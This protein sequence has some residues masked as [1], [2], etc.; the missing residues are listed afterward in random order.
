MGSLVGD[1][2]VSLQTD[3]SCAEGKYWIITEII[4]ETKKKEV[5]RR[6]VSVFGDSGARETQYMKRRRSDVRPA[7]LST[8]NK[9]ARLVEFDSSEEDPNACLG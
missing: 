8:L 6:R 3:Q 4:L 9:N 2:P 5:K 1:G 7:N